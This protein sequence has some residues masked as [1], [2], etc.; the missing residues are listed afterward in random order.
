MIALSGVDAAAL[1]VSLSILG[2]GF[3]V[4]LFGRRGW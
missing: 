2:V 1:E 3:F 4:W